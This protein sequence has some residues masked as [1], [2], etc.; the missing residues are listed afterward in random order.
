LQNKATPNWKLEAARLKKRWSIVFAS[1][2]AGVSVNT[3]NRWERGLQLPQL[4][5]LDQLCKSFDMSPEELGFE[6]IIIAK[7]RTKAT[8]QN[9][10]STDNSVVDEQLPVNSATQEM[11]ASFPQFPHFSNEFTPYVKQIKK[12]LNEID[13]AQKSDVTE[14]GESLLRRQ[15]VTLLVSTPAVVF[16]LKQ[17]RREQPL[18]S[19]EILS[20]SSI[21]LP[22]CWQ[23]YYE[24][25]LSELNRVLPD[26]ITQLSALA[27]QPSRHHKWAANLASQTHQLGYLL[28]LQR[29]DF[30]TSLKHIQEATRYGQVAV[31]VNLQVASLA[32]KA[33]VYFCLDRDRQR[34]QAYQE[35]LRLCDTCSPLLKGYIYAGLAETHASYRDDTTA[36]EFLKLARDN[37]PDRPEDDP[38]YAYTHFRWPTFYNFAGQVYLHLNQSRQAWEAFANVD[39]LVPVSEEPYRVELAV[40]QAA[41]ALALGEQ[42][43]SCALVETAVKS[44]RALGSNLRYDETYMIYERMQEKWGQEPRVRALEDLFY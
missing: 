12:G 33:Y 20:L 28:A 14:Y 18:H 41:T 24:G 43:Q 23:L 22:L 8:T 13:Q 2:K 21:S 38:V 42:E 39:Q 1:K 40:N 44:A 16:G 27:Q 25:G 15:A 11:P 4:E 34:L 19:D 32:R 9:Q 35:A 37:Y 26:Y 3:F 6:N 29:Q 30:G 36:H 5:T 17:D 10:T 31:D 7:R